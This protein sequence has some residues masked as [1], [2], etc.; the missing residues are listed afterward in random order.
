MKTVSENS[1]TI[2]NAPTFKLYGSQN[3]KR[4][5]LRKEEKKRKRKGLRKYL[6][7]L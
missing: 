2:L 6:K 5:R 1:G 3:K 7:R 4:K